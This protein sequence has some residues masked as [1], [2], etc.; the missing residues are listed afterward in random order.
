MSVLKISVPNWEK[1]NPRKDRENH[2]WFRFENR[3]FEDQRIFSLTGDQQRLL[4]MVYSLRSK[5]TK[6]TAELSI[7]YAS[8]MLKIGCDEVNQGLQALHDAGLV[9]VQEFAITPSSRR[10]KAVIT[11]SNG[12]PTRRNDTLRDETERNDTDDTVPAAQSR[13]AP[14]AGSPVWDAYESAYE[15]RYKTKPVRNAKTNSLCT[16]LVKRLGADDAPE[17]ARFFLSHRDAYYSKRGHPL[18]SL[19]ADAE[20]LRTEWATGRLIT[21]GDARAGELRQGNVQAAKKAIERMGGGNG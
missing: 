2:S 11:P 15:S 1:F 17:V 19:V 21:S 9:V 4:I 20:K 5:D 14:G 10:R 8:A 16:Q 7:P 3:F 13:A 18:T 12:S 6:T